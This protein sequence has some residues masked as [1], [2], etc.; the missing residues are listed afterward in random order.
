MRGSV[1]MVT[2]SQDRDKGSHGGPAA[3]N[4]GSLPALE[5]D[6]SGAGEGT[7]AGK[8]KGDVTGDGSTRW[9]FRPGFV[10]IFLPPPFPF[11]RCNY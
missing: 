2:V 5:A 6:T 8:Q 4:D 11:P 10:R 1:Q 7:V 3:T 9:K